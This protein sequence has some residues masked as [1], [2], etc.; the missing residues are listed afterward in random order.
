MGQGK[1]LL[2]SAHDSIIGAR[3]K[4]TRNANRRRQS[5]PFKDG[6]FVYLSTKNISY[7]KGLAR[8]L[9]P[10]FI[11][12]YKI[13]KDFG[14]YSFKLEFPM[15][16]KRRGIHDVYHL[17]LLRIHL[18]NDDRLFPGRMDTQ[19]GNGPGTNDEWA[20]QRIR[21][22]AGSGEDA[23]F[24]ILWKSGDVTWLL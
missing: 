12:P 24:E 22:H 1:V 5:V 6:D 3:V 13:A 20:V 10:K 14:N 17:S 19:I 9:I 23:I 4:Q 16:L 18:P 11:G 15:H 2:M 21:S 8:K 7:E